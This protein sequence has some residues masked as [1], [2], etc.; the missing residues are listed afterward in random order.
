MRKEINKKA[1]SLMLSYVILI[2]IAISLAIGVYAWLKFQANIEELDKCPDDVSLILQNYECNLE[3][4]EISLTVQN[5]GLFNLDG[6][7]VRGADTSGE[8]PAVVL[9]PE[10]EVQV[11]TGRYDFANE[12]AP[13]AK[14]DVSFSFRDKGLDNLIKIQI[15][16]FRIQKDKKG[17]DKVVFC[18]NA[19]ITQDI[20]CEIPEEKCWEIQGDACVEI[21]CPEPIENC[22]APDCYASLASCEAELPEEPIIPDSLVSWW[23]F[24]G[25]CSDSGNE[26]NDGENHGGTIS[27]DGRVGS[28]LSF[29]SG[30][31]YVKVTDD[32]S[33]KPVES[34]LT[35]ELWIKPAPIR[36]DRGIINKE[37]DYKIYVNSDSKIETLVGGKKIVSDNLISSNNWYYL[38]VVWDGSILR[39]YVDNV[40][41]T[42]TAPLSSITYNSNNLLIGTDI[43]GNSNFVGSIDELAV[44]NQALDA[45]TILEHYQNTVDGSGDYFTPN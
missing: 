34:L 13:N 9:A 31:N 44:Y 12:F 36:P 26:N 45:T 8:I 39:M 1:V 29:S 25:D 6:F 28:A 43:I 15:E 40:L 20:V 42:N 32:D 18:D 38:V 41:Q 19:V 24:E 5:K 27:L 17:Q 11:G 16:P 3:T 21:T 4:K 14:E 10:N 7:I 35:I 2:V 33:L 23:K 30:Q 22:V 37:K